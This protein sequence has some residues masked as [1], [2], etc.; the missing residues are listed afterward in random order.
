MKAALALAVLLAQMA[1][2]WVHLAAG[3][4]SL[5]APPGS[6][7]KMVEPQIWELH[8]RALTLGIAA[9]PKVAD[10]DDGEP[11]RCYAME[12]LPFDRGRADLRATR[13]TARA[14]CPEGYFSLYRPPARPGSPALFLW[15]W[16][17][18]ADGAA[19][20]RAVIRSLRLGAAP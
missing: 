7:L 9:G 2:G 14:D 17:D 8:N 16:D 4:L 6:T 5:D 3:A 12:I 15:A 18:T 13:P 11:R 20:V 19:T 1:P 10:A